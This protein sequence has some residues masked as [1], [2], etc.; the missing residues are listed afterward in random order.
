M[1]LR[2]I[3]VQGRAGRWF[4]RHWCDIEPSATSKSRESSEKSVCSLSDA[5]ALRV[6]VDDH[7]S[8]VL[9]EE[10]RNGHG[11]KQLEGPINFFLPHSRTSAVT[12]TTP[13]CDPTMA[14]S[15]IFENGKL[16]P[17]IYK[18]QSISTETYLDIDVPS[19][20]VCGRPK[21]DLGEGRG[22]VR[23]HTRHMGSH[24]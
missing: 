13:S 8:S 10:G 12:R 3:G 24:I 5:N 1:I 21:K 22:F 6:W 18:I 7:G 2:E 17:G 4:R 9:G 14:P 16:K 23:S 11:S 20:E 15:S 19:R